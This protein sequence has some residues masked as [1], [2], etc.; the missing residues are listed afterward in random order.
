[1]RSAPNL[2]TALACLQDDTELYVQ[3]DQSRPKRRF[4]FPLSVVSARS[5]FEHAQMRQEKEAA[6]FT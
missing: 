6:I 1:V 3:F 4:A 5:G 2:Q